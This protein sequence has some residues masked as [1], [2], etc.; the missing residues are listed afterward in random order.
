MRD[1]N[2]R[3]E[4]LISWI[5]RVKKYFTAKGITLHYDPSKS[6][7]FIVE[8]V[9]EQAVKGQKTGQGSKYA[10]AVL[11]HMVGAKLSLILCDQAIEHRGYSVADDPS[12]GSGDFELGDV[13][14]HV[15]TTPSEALLRKCQK[16][17]DAGRRPMI[18]TT[19]RGIAGA[20]YLAKVQDIEQRVDIVEAEQFIAANLYKLSL[21]K[22][23]DRKLT[24]EKFIQ[25]YNEIVTKH[26]TDPGLKIGFG[27]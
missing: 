5:E 1:H 23:S 22:A 7:K 21:F 27:K 24:V 6:F 20:V 11:Q 16:N 12:S 2:N 17:I 26:E 9:L 14:I 13:V 15:T 3:W 25:R 10:G 8:D 19:E 4:P 18:I